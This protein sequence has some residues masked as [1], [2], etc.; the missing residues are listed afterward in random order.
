MILINNRLV[1]LGHKSIR[2]LNPDDLVI[3]EGFA[4]PK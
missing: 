1:A 4:A 3:P 2:E